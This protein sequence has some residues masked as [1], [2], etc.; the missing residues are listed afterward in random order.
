[1]LAILMIFIP[2]IFPN[3]VG[4]KDK[5]D[6]VMKRYKNSTGLTKQEIPKGIKIK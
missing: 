2:L 6:I 3:A 1:M 5:T 4:E